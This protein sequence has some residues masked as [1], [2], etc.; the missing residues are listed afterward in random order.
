MK[1]AV[2]YEEL[3]KGIK[4]VAR[5]FPDDVRYMDALDELEMLPEA[6]KDAC[7][8]AMKGS[9]EQVRGSTAAVF[10]AGLDRY[11]RELFHIGYTGPHDAI[12]TDRVADDEVLDAMAYLTARRTGTLRYGAKA[13]RIVEDLIKRLRVDRSRYGAVDGIAESATWH[14]HQRQNALTEAIR[15]AMDDIER[16]DADSD[17]WPV[18]TLAGTDIRMRKCADEDKRAGRFVA[19][20]LTEEDHGAVRFNTPAEAVKKLAAWY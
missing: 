19:Y 7:T 3:L 6:V 4:R 15:W 20:R 9:V 12:M 16:L 8:G 17:P 14:G 11:E 2:L 1:A 10:F 13:F 18:A 5:R